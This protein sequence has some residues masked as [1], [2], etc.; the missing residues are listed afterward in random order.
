MPPMTPEI[1]SALLSAARCAST[2]AGWRSVRPWLAL[3]DAEP[4][5]EESAPVWPP[6]C[7]KQDLAA[8]NA[9]RRET[10]DRI[11]AE[12]ADDIQA[13]QYRGSWRTRRAWVLKH[14]GNDPVVTV[15][16]IRARILAAE[17]EN[18]HHR[19]IQRALVSAGYVCV[20]PDDTTGRNG[21]YQ[22]RRGDVTP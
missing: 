14:A 11:C 19:T 22:W 17:G 12:I 1:I 2:A 18:V 20:N 5:P 21:G 15:P 4:E 3:A 16:E 8:A 13:G 10:F 6:P 9:V 7:D